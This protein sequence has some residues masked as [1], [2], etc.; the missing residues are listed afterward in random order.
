MIRRTL[1]VALP[2]F[3]LSL[4]ACKHD[5]PAAAENPSGAAPAKSV[6]E[7]TTVHTQ[8]VSNQLVLPAK[9]TP[10]P[11]S[12]VHIF[13]PISGRVVELKVLPGQDL[14]KGQQIGLLQSSD[15]AQTRSDFEKAKIEAARADLQLN[16]AK[17]LLQH[18]VMAQRDYD[19]L[20]AMDD[21]DHSEL[22]RARQALHIL[23]FSENDTSDVIP[24][25]APISGAVLDVGTAN[26]ELQRSL[27]NA[28]AIATIAD[29]SSIWVVGDLYPR[30]LDKVKVGQSV[31]IN[32]T[33]YPD[34]VYHGTVSNI[35]DAVDP[36]SLTLKVR[37]VLANPGHK[38]K[39]QMYANIAVTNQK[40]TSIVVPATAVIQNGKNIFVFVET[41]PGKY[42][43]RDVVLGETHD[44]SDEI[45]QGLQDGDRVVITGAELL[46]ESEAE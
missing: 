45:T 27:D 19:D 16:R 21:A 31:D 1:A 44:T 29:I 25:R 38:L 3:L 7:T 9:V 36:T 43:R 8:Q 37:V 10:N 46:R 11:T 20:K 41:T 23:G 2:F 30:D 22:E 18:Q 34:N 35:S 6:V 13:P 26:G 17:E 28:N 39:P 14:A 4:T 24:I 15:A 42:E 12:V 32:V 33:G 5:Q 40:R